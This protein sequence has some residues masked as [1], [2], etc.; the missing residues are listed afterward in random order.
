MEALGYH[1]L[2]AGITNQKLALL[3]LFLFAHEAGCPVILPDIWVMDGTHKTRAIVPIARV[4]ELDALSDF[5]R[6]YGIDI[7]KSGPRASEQQSWPYFGKGWQATIGHPIRE[8]ALATQGFIPD[9]IRSLV[10][11]ARS[12]FTVSQLTHTIFDR[13]VPVVAAQFRIE[14]DWQQH[15]AKDLDPRLEG[16]EDY[17]ISYDRILTKIHNSLPD[18]KSIYVVCDEPALLVPKQIIREHAISCFGI[19]LIWKSDFLTRFEM[20]AFTALDLSI[21]DFEMA[22]VPARFVGMSRSTFSN[23]VTFD[24]F[25]RTRAHV[26]GHYV[27]NMLG[28][29]LGRRTDDGRSPSP[30]MATGLPMPPSGVGP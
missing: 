27:Y 17:C 21:I 5:A 20:E 3:G 19:E 14:A 23:M 12:S 8:V 18:A 25:C 26:E 29:A 2:P 4:F 24:K 9:F 16:K 11:I 6:T 15:S 13:P 28:D 10:P 1:V 7:L 22:A 30:L